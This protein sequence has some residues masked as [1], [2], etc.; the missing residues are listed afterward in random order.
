[1][2]YFIRI[3]YTKGDAIVK[4]IVN[5][6]S[7][8]KK[9]NGSDLIEFEFV[10]LKPVPDG[11]KS[12]FLFSIISGLPIVSEKVKELIESLNIGFQ[13]IKTTIPSYFLMNT[14]EPI[15]AF[16]WEQSIYER[17]PSFLP[18]VADMPMEIEKLVF[19]ESIIGIDIFRMYEEPISLFI[20]VKLKEVFE[21]GGVTG[22]EYI[23]ISEYTYGIY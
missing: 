16:D 4:S 6:D 1:M 14:M 19:N 20:S 15:K 5:L 3:K 7:I 8:K 2:H 12:D 9:I 23:P 18:E 10:E 21:N 13:F 11:I 17:N 22:L